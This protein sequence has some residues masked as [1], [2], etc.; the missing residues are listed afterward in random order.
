MT[1][2][3]ERRL[4]VV[5]C[6]LALLSNGNYSLAQERNVP[7]KKI[8]PGAVNVL[9]AGTF[10]FFGATYFGKVVKSAP[11]SATAITEHIQTLGDGNQIIRKQEAK[12][13][14]DG[15]GRTRLDQ[16]LDTIG[17]W[18]AAGDAPQMIYI[19][20]PVTGNSYN[21]DPRS[22]T[23]RKSTNAR[24]VA[25]RQKIELD[26]EQRRREH[27]ARVKE[28][29]KRVKEQ[30]KE[31]EA[32]TKERIRE[33]EM[34]VKERATQHEARIKEQARER[35]LRNKERA[36]EHEARVKE[37]EKRIREQT[38]EHEERMKER[39]KE[40]EE[41][42]KEHQARAK[43]R[44]ERIKE[45]NKEREKRIKE[46]KE[47]VKEQTIQ[48]KDQAKLMEKKVEG[49]VQLKEKAFAP[50]STLITKEGAASKETSS[51]DGK[52]K[53]ESLGKQTIEGVEAEG[54]RSTRSIAVG[55]IGN[56]LPIEII[57]ESWYSPDLQVLVMTKH[58]DPRSGVRTYR[59]T[60]IERSEPQRSLFE[61][62][63]DYTFQDEPIRKKIITKP[64]LPK[65]S[66]PMKKPESPKSLEPKKPEPPKAPALHL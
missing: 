39:T 65:N 56:T 27:E 63:A 13:Y 51:P 48:R 30:A 60:H 47:R 41:R 18:T 17:K 14:R 9:P 7:V 44:G 61:V 64:E 52:K 2:K 28:H 42:V 21:L 16:K 53:I 36:A 49:Q 59:L 33:H 43:E 26:N 6:S 40:H 10:K 22:R 15:E 20:D 35:E 50:G 4:L 29:E 34:R 54:T 31:H 55:E 8:A 45:Q 3:R 25:L 38:K 58:S 62:P 32:R 46:Q 24:G 23:V 57:E 37:H 19:N 11:Y 1:T 66:E 5:I 12:V